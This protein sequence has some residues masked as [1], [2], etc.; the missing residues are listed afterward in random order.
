MVILW[1]RTD[2]LKWGKE[3]REYATK[4]PFHFIVFFPFFSRWAEA[5]QLPLTNNNK[6]PGKKKVHSKCV[7]VG[8]R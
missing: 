5:L 7:C 4:I 3:E 8:V 1:E 2:I 6:Q